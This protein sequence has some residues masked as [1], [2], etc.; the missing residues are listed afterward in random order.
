M[1]AKKVLIPQK[2]Q[3]AGHQLKYHGKANP[4]IAECSWAKGHPCTYDT[5]IGKYGSV[6]VSEGAEGDSISVVLNPQCAEFL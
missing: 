4:I 2:A 6:L 1:S 3:W 5:T